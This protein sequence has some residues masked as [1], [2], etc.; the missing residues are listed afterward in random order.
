MTFDPAESRPDVMAS[1]MNAY[2]WSA[3]ASG[4]VTP[5]TGPR[6][7]VLAFIVLYDMCYSIGCQVE[8]AQPASVRRYVHGHPGE[9]GDEV[10]TR[11][12]S[13]RGG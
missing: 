12:E 1:R 10:S 13:D 5:R 7:G 9:H 11:R 8:G 4:R 6:S 3:S 2:A